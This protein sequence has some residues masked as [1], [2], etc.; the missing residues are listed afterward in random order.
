[1]IR[2]DIAITDHKTNRVVASFDSY[3]DNANETEIL[4]HD[5]VKEL[6]ELMTASFETASEDA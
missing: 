6:F 2:I 3:T 1:M 4:F 5:K